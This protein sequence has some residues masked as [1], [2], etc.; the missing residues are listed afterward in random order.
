MRNLYVYI[1]A[2]AALLALVYAHE[3]NPYWMH[4]AIIA[5][6][7][8]I[9]ASSWSLLADPWPHSARNPVNSMTCV[10]A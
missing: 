8:G 5:M 3:L 2:A 7:Y 6:Y 1:L 9:L 4:V 10:S